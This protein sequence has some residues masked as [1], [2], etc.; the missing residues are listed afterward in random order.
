MAETK[1]QENPCTLILDIEIEPEKVSKAFDR[2]YREFSGFT[3]VPGFR[4]GKAPRAMLEKYVNQERLRER[5]MEVL[6]GPAYREEIQRREIKP[7]TE[8]EVEFGDLANGRPWQFKA[9]VPLPPRVSLGD[10]STISIERPK[11]SVSND[12][13]EKHI[14][15]MRNERARLEAVTDRPAREE[16]VLITETAITPE[17]GAPPAQP[18]RTLI[19]LGNNIPGFDEAVIGMSIDEERTFELT[20][21]DDYQEEDLKGKKASFHVKLL[22]I[23]Q[24]VVPELNEEWVKDATGFQTVKELKSDVKEKLGESYAQLADRV[25]ENRIVEE[26]I[27]RSQIDFPDV[28]VGEEMAQ[29]MQELEEEIKGRMNFEQYLKAAGLTEEQHRQRIASQAVDRINSTLAL[30]ELV[31]AEN[32]TAADEEVDAE[33]DRLAEGSELSPEQLA[34]MKK[35]KNRRLQASNLVVKRKLRELLFKKAKIKDV[36]VKD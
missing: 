9:T 24:R 32:V 26:L 29:I 12:D 30:R 33:F 22:S 15:S 1:E 35:D 34:G 3:N 19:R 31:K 5:V 2:A 25:A 17:G 11:Y 27:K 4:P 16:D 28:M 36:A 14:E 6:A 23:N 7:Y 13:V 21:P 10:Y 20:Y 8:P 18:K